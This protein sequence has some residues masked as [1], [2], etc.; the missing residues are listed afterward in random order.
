MKHSSDRELAHKRCCRI[1]SSSTPRC[2]G[3]FPSAR[4]SKC[5]PDF[6]LGEASLIIPSVAFSLSWE[7]PDSRK[8]LLFSKHEDRGS[9][10]KISFQ[11]CAS[12]G[13]FQIQDLKTVPWRNSYLLQPFC[14]SH[15]CKEMAFFNILSSRDFTRPRHHWSLCEHKEMLNCKKMKCM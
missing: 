5:R 9:S 6:S 8:Q 2:N 4:V 14:K 11:L 1:I 3:A 15:P 12:R 7:G 10:G 13:W